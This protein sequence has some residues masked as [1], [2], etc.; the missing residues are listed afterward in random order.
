M[1]KH[2]VFRGRLGLHCSLWLA[3]APGLLPAQSNPNPNP[4]RPANPLSRLAGSPRRPNIIFIL[5]DD[6]G[7]GDVGCYG[8]RKIQT[9]NLDR[10]AAEGD[11]FYEFL[12]REHRL[13][14]VALRP[15]DRPA[16]RSCLHPRQ[17]HRGAPARDGTVAEVLRTGR[18]L[19]R[20]GGQVGPGRP[21]EPG[22]RG[23]KGSTI[24]WGT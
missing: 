3:A 16:H 4:N 12:C 21:S 7:Y 18:V 10:L 23:T 17:R 13:R 5:A 19:D 24:S 6:L 14:A 22:A 2:E 11:A 15:D 20:D 8:Q 9:P 1:N